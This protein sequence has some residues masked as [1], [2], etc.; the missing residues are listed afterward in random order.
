MKRR[1]VRKNRPHNRSHHFA[2]LT[3]ALIAQ[4]EHEFCSGAVCVQTG[5]WAYLRSQA[6]FG[7]IDEMTPEM[8]DALVHRFKIKN[9]EWIEAEILKFPREL[10]IPPRVFK[11]LSIDGE[12]PFKRTKREPFYK[13]T[14]EAPKD[15]LVLD[16]SFALG[17]FL[18]GETRTLFFDRKLGVTRQLVCIARDACEK[19][20]DLRVIYVL[21]KARPEEPAE[22]RQ[23]LPSSVEI[24]AS[25]INSPLQIVAEVPDF[26]LSRAQS[27]AEQGKET[28]LIVDGLTY[29]ANALNSIKLS[30]SGKIQ[31]GEVSLFFRSVEKLRQF[32]QASWR[33]KNGGSISILAGIRRKSEPNVVDRELA[34][35]VSSIV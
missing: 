30:Q 8:T 7:K 34:D 2:P 32:L 16:R 1:R 17:T 11:V 24:Y 14:A 33:L 29:W 5:G 3:E 6:S 35:L 4:A 12:N 23:N 31:E 19:N 20:P 26:A 9:A 22:L 27:L 28:L 21:V 18:K 25:Y 15:E 13:M 10:S